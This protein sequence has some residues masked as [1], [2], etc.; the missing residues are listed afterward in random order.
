MVTHITF[1]FPAM[2][3]LYKQKKNSSPS[4][5]RCLIFFST[6]T[7]KSKKKTTIMK[8]ALVE[9]KEEETESRHDLKSL[10]EIYCNKHSKN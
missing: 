5:F 8:E 6:I 3:E 7:V 1:P 9:S 2:F 10:N 4:F